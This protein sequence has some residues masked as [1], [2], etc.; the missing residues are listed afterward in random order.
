METTRERKKA[1][2]TTTLDVRF[3]RVNDLQEV[4]GTKNGEVDWIQ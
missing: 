3:G 4:T 2:C 1:V